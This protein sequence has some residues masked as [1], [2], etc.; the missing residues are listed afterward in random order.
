MR[1][2]KKLIVIISVVLILAIASAVFAYLY[3]MTDIFKS[4]QE[5]FAKYFGQNEEML[6]KITDLK[7]VEVYKNL[8]NENKYELDTNIK[9]S[10]SEGGEISNPLNNLTAKFNI[11]KDNQEQYTYVDSQ[12]LYDDEEYLETE[13]IKEQDV[14]GVRFTDAIKQFIT[15]KNDENINEIMSDIGLTPEQSEDLINLLGSK[16][17]NNEKITTLKNKY[18]D[19]AKSAIIN[20]EFSKRKNAIITYNNNTIKTNAYSALLT[21]EQVE[22]LL[23]EILNNIKNETDLLQNI[24][25]KENFIKIID[26]TIK[27]V[28]EEIE[29]PTI[30]IIVYEYKRNTIKT[31]LEMG[32]YNISIENVEQNQELKTKINYSNLSDESLV[33]TEINISRTNYENEEKFEIIANI[34]EE[35]D[36]YIITFSNIMQLLQNQIEVNTE[37]GFKHGII[38]SSLVIENNVNIG[39]DFEKGQILERENSRLISSLEESKRKEMINIIKNIV[40]QKTIE[41]INLLTEKM[42]INNNENENK[43]V[44]NEISQ[45]EINKFNA[46]F[47]FYTGE[48]VSAENVKMLLDVVKNNISSY[49]FLNSETPENSDSIIAENNK[50]NIKI[51]IE[52]DK[53]DEEGINKILEKIDTNKKYK[54]SI[55]YKE[56]N[57]LIEYINITEI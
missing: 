45:V 43:N 26:E 35:D 39:Q 16:T 11:Q 8:K 25:D 57:G 2:N 56:S 28:S 51:N 15:V 38:T 24:S 48:E 54:V 53:T 14:Y 10:Y 50:V 18:L 19:I 22:N 33:E 31:V 9:I 29:I 6:Q 27:S 46:K 5:L 37:I 1:K 12:I 44:E 7:T 55:N 52:K 41:R 49:E 23:I 3:L 34:T 36:N 42:E 32:G 4:N 21:S 40:M 20:G 13:F 17:N 30:K 47:E